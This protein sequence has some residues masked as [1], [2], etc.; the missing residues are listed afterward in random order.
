MVEFEF[1]EAFGFEVMEGAGDFCGVEGRL[2]EL[3]LT[4]V[5]VGERVLL[6]EGFNEEDGLLMFRDREAGGPTG[7]IREPNS[8]PIVTS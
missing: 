2:L 1:G 5:D 7:T 4:R 3:L 8:T 6:F